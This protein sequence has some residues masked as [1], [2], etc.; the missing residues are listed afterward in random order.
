M[1]EHN[2]EHALNT[3]RLYAIRIN[4]NRQTL[5]ISPVIGS[6]GYTLKYFITNIKFKSTCK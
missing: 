6:T 4:V 1:I 5:L 3:I 2:K